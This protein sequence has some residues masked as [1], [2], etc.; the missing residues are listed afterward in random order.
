MERARFVLLGFV[1]AISLLLAGCGGGGSDEASGPLV[2]AAPKPGSKAAA[3]GVPVSKGGDNS[4]QTW[5][6]EGSNTLNSR[7]TVIVGAFLNARAREDW[8]EAC[9][10]LAAKQRRM[11]ERLAPD[12]SGNGACAMGMALLARHIPRRAF[13]REAEIRQFLSL[14]VGAGKAFLIYVRPGGKVYA[15]ALRREGTAW[16]VVSV[17]ATALD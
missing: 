6:V 13:E 16:K 10:Y 17:G 7:V 4:I 5:G 1:L 12:N 2:T 8:S 11:F 14:R 9:A 3:P 15:T